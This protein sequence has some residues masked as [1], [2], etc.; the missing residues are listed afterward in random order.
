MSEP[1]KI[2][3]KARNNNKR[4][5]YYVYIFVGNVS[6]EI[7][8]I[9]DVIKDLNLYDTLIKLSANDYKTME[10]TYGSSWFVHFFNIQHIQVT[11]NNINNSTIQTQELMT[12]YGDSWFT[13]HIKEFKF[14][15]KSI[16]YTYE[17]LIQHKNQYNKKLR[18]MGTLNEDEN[19]TTNAKEI[20]GKSKQIGGFSTHNLTDSIL[21]HKKIDI[22]RVNRHGVSEDVFDGDKLKQ[23]E[24]VDFKLAVQQSGGGK[25]HKNAHK[26]GAKGKDNNNDKE[27]DKE[28]DKEEDNAADEEEDDDVDEEEGAQEG[29]QE[30]Q[31]DDIVNI[32][33][34]NVDEE[35]MNDI[36]AETDVVPDADVEYTTKMINSAL[37]EDEKIQNIKNTMIDFDVSKDDNMYDD[38]LKDVFAK[39]YVKNQYIYK[40]D[41]INILK[42]KICCGIKNNPKFGSYPY[43]LPSRQYLWCEYVFNDA[44]EKIMIGHKWMKKNNILNVDMEPNN[45]FRVYEELR[46]PL[47]NLKNNLRSYVNKIRMEDDEYNILYDYNTYLTNN[48]IYMVDIYNELGKNY[49]CTPNAYK[50]IQD[51]YLKLF[52]P[53]IRTDE[54]KNIIDYVGKT[55]KIESSKIMTYFNS[56]INDLIL[57]NEITNLVEKTKDTEYK[58]LF[59]ENYIQNAVIHINMRF[60]NEKTI[61]LHRMFYDFVINEEFPFIQYKM[62]DNTIDYK[63]H[64]SEI[65]KMNV[66]NKDI[67]AKWFENSQH[68]ITVRMRINNKYI[69]ININELGRIEYKMRW[70]EEERANEQDIQITYAY[71]KTLIKKINE[72]SKKPILEIPEDSDFFYAF[73]NSIQKFELPGNHVINHNDLSE[74]SRYFYPY[75]SLIIAPQKRHSKKNIGKEDTSKFGTYLK[76][77]RISKYDNQSKREL[78]IL[79]LIKNYELTES[80]VANVIAK[81]F[82]MTIENALEEYKNVKKKYINIK[83]SRKILKKYEEI[84]HFKSPG[85]NIEIQGKTR[86]NYKIRIAGARDMMQLQRIITFMNILIFLY[87]ETYLHKK[88][89]NKY[90]L[91]KLKLLTDVAERR[92]M[93]DHFVMPEKEISNVKQI[94]QIDKKRISLSSTKGNMQWSRKCQNS[95][96]DKRRQPRIYNNDNID[97]LLKRGYMLNKKTGSYQKKIIYKDKHGKPSE[98]TLKSIKLAEY[99]DEGNLNGNELHYTCDPETNGEHFY[100]GFLMDTNCAPCCF[101]KDPNETKNKEK[102]N[103]FLKCLGNELKQSNQAVENNIEN[104]ESL[105][106]L[107]DINNMSANRIGFLPKYIDIYVNLM[108]DNTKN[109]KNNYLTF[110]PGYY[111][112]FGS[113]DAAIQNQKKPA[114]GFLNAISV[115]TNIS[116]NEIKK[117]CIDALANDSNKKLFTHLNEGDIRT[118][119]GTVEAY[120]EYINKTNNIP[121]EM[122]ANI[123][124]LPHILFKHGLNILLFQKKTIKIT[125]TLEKEKIMDDFVLNTQIIY[126]DDLTTDNKN[127]IIII[128]YD[129]EFIP[130]VFIKKTNPLSKNFDKTFI[131][132]YENVSN[133]LIK[134]I[135]VFLTKNKANI[136]T[137]DLLLD[138][139][140]TAKNIQNAINKL[141]KS[142][143]AIVMQIID[144][145]NKCKYIITKNGLIIPIMPSATLY[146]VKIIK[147]YETYVKS[148]DETY[149][150]LTELYEKTNKTLKLMPIG[151]YCTDSMSDK[152][153]HS[154]LN[155]IGIFTHH[156]NFIETIP[157]KISIDIINKY[158]LKYENKLNYDNIDAEIVKGKDN[159]IVDDRIVRVKQELYNNEM[160]QL[161]RLE[162]STYINNPDNSVLKK[163]MLKIITNDSDIK[164]KIDNIRLILY[165]LV[166]VELYDEYYK[167]VGSDMGENIE[168]NIDVGV[169]KGGK[170][171]KLLNLINKTPNILDF[172]INNDRY[173]CNTLDVNKCGSKTASHCNWVHNSCYM[174][175]SKELSIIFINHISEEL[176]LYDIKAY[177]LLNL[178]EYYVSDIIN[179]N[180]YNEYPN[181]IIFK[182]S[183][184]NNSKIIQELLNDEIP[185]IG[186]KQVKTSIT[187]YMQLNADNPL[188]KMS[189]MYVQNIYN[190][191]LMIF[192]AFAVAYYWLFNKN[193]DIDSRNMGYYS[194]LQTGL[195]NYFRSCVIDWC[196]IEI[197][198]E[199]LYKNMSEYML[200]NIDDFKINLITKHS[201]YSTFIIELYIM[202]KITK[203]P[204][205]V[206]NNNMQIIYVFDSSFHIDITPSLTGKYEKSSEYINLKFYFKDHKIIPYNLEVIYFI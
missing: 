190:Q 100:V 15:N 47:E 72:C 162:F 138:K 201:L 126:E 159:F 175:V 30:G 74:F 130:V 120:S 63:F 177:E 204:I 90:I 146:D 119:F 86:D 198:T 199:D 206:Y 129:D 161:F 123:I 22:T 174:S 35:S 10:K 115:I 88:K 98:Y 65:K 139:Q 4:K 78:R 12:K 46:E 195:A 82:N 45:N 95:G 131:F 116:E 141:K 173:A 38:N 143:F 152:K 69:S 62:L 165:R 52:Y 99:D 42:N 77:K 85:I 76:Y 58:K 134:H 18:A 118:K 34:E 64:E 132:K 92:H 33:E 3:W 186:K 66:E 37:I 84:T 8:A 5:Q 94:A 145:R 180:Y 170:Y 185:L 137:D 28:D 103:Y 182:N 40:D 27:D 105:Y 108:M 148:F 106:V 80:G 184:I 50:N 181:Q 200:S 167:L 197:N 122:I 166:D 6:D 96:T 14:Q 178:N 20:L 110:T 89:E 59:K 151:V 163:K 32:D 127:N 44:R 133:N 155:I 153:K 41:T 61:N 55:S 188:K 144:T 135:N 75:V 9:L 16:L 19:Y 29:D 154:E 68:G 112:G 124:S 17:G 202:H 79:Y 121:Y 125:K 36:I 104:N 157:E 81:Q 54:L 171:K 140:Y 179:Y 158:G 149:K 111:F 2:I 107:Q 93:V 203:T 176:A 187:N 114:N 71:L 172:K 101:K 194:S 109:I 160:Y 73:V 39:Y 117:M 83:K 31:I 136:I 56:K 113:T 53:K 25:K 142:D 43:L 196:R 49:S 205:V 128:E 48:E 24:Y 183:N 51:I 164:V 191:D 91:K 70:K 1:I 189:N 147:S 7:S 13:T 60:I 87:A 193:L 168:E 150:L 156:N 11:I 192:R 23:I 21:K 169:Q 26:R 57:Y 102:K 67:L 97:D